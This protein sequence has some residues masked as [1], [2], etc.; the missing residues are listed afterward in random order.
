MDF[1]KVSMADTLKLAKDGTLK[2]WDIE[3]VMGAEVFYNITDFL[4]EVNTDVPMRFFNDRILMNMFSPDNIQY[5]EVDI[6]KVVL[7]RYQYDGDGTEIGTDMG[8]IILVDMKILVEEFKNNIGMGSPVKVRVDTRGMKRIEFHFGAN[9][10]DKDFVGEADTILWARLVDPEEIN[11]K[12]SGMPE[13]VKK[14]RESSGTEKA[15]LVFEPMTFQK[16]TN[17]GGKGRG[18]GSGN[19]DPRFVMKVDK[20]GVIVSSGDKMAGRIFRVTDASQTNTMT[21]EEIVQKENI[22]KD[23]VGTNS[24]ISP[25]STYTEQYNMGDDDGGDSSDIGYDDDS[26]VGYAKRDDRRSKKSTDYKK[27]NKGSQKAEAVKDYKKAADKHNL[28]LLQ[29]D[30][31]QYVCF[32][33]DYAK[34]F[35]KLKG[36]SFITI[37]IRTNAPVVIEQKNNDIRCLLTIAPR[38]ESEDDL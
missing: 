33:R 36:L 8:T 3:F 13:K 15:T 34:C 32:E 5:A 11:R 26:N 38:V 37:E 28:L 4:T 23:S 29:A 2:K 19:V 17:L 21:M 20:G 24:D 10:A 1:D 22:G 31:P 6:P 16:L 30:K 25:D 27:D 12:L 7:T 9:E 14:G 18:T 35:L